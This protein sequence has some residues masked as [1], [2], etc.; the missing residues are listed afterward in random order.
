LECRPAFKR[1][2]DF[3]LY[4]QKT[5]DTSDTVKG[6]LEERQKEVW[7]GLVRITDDQVL[8]AEKLVQQQQFDEARK[9]AEELE[10]SKTLLRSYQ[11]A[12]E[13]QAV[14]EALQ[15]KIDKVVASIATE[16]KLHDFL[17][18]AKEKLAKPTAPVIAEVE[19][20]A[21]KQGYQDHPRFHPLLT[22]AKLAIR[23]EIKFLADAKPAE[24]PPASGEFT[25]LLIG[26]GATG[27][28]AAGEK[29]IFA[30]ARGVLY[31]LT[32][33]K[34]QILWAA[35]VGIDAERFRCACRPRAAACRKRS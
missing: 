26:G 8:E 27:Q 11:P 15:G 23:A 16:R 2:T 20:E 30:L 34:G 10:H 33:S 13:N 28:P 17:N 9:A 25:S 24:R 18:W 6:F 1:R 35:R 3:S 19:G 4:L 7:D 12:N 21:K 14:P 31:G 5:K 29:V 32:E 22:E